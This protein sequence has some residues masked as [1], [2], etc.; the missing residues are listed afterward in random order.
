MYF[1]NADTGPYGLGALVRRLTETHSKNNLIFFLSRSLKSLLLGTEMNLYF[2]GRDGIFVTNSVPLSTT[3]QG[4]KLILFC[5]RSIGVEPI[6]LELS[7]V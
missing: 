5:F 7:L 1:Q 3:L 6:Y 4:V 2:I